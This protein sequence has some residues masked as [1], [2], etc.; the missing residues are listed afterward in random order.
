[1]RALDGLI[2]GLRD[3]EADHGSAAA[4]RTITS[5]KPADGL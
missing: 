2:D 5:L 3:G 4:N 1:V